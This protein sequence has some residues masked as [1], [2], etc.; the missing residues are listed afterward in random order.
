MVSLGM[1]WL[2]IYNN[3]IKKGNF[4]ENCGIFTETFHFITFTYTHLITK[5]QRVAKFRMQAGSSDTYS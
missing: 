3:I 4:S 1:Y 5:W 2:E